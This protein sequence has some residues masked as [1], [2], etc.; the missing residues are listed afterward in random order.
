MPRE[1]KFKWSR[2]LLWRTD[3]NKS[4]TRALLQK[5][6]QWR[7]LPY[8]DHSPWAA[9]LL[10]FRPCGDFA[11]AF[12]YVVGP[13]FERSAFILSSLLCCTPLRSAKSF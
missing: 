11:S 10:Y 12:A 6:L 3:H 4:A 2:T 9:L 13:S 8:L 1:K 7:P 5:P